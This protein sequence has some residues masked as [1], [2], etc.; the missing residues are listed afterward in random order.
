M[1]C[2][3]VNYKITVAESPIIKVGGR[4]EDEQIL[5]RYQEAVNTLDKLKDEVSDLDEL[6]MQM[7][8][9]AGLYAIT[10]EEI[11]RLF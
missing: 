2:C 5:I 4:F 10:P 6:W 8:N 11:F 1:S 3:E 9:E 7:M